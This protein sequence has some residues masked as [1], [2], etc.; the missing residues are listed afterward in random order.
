MGERLTTITDEN[1]SPRLP[2]NETA[3]YSRRASLYVH[4]QRP[5]SGLKMGQRVVGSKPRLQTCIYY[6]SATRS[7]TKRTMRAGD[8][9]LPMHFSIKT[10]ISILFI[11]YA[12]T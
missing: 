7:G 1:K 8:A 6:T 4:M 3:G 5:E 11:F 2:W 9:S 10:T 12:S